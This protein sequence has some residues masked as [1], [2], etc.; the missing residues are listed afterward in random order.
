[1]LDI[2]DLDDSV[3][4]T[5]FTLDDFR[6][7]LLK[8]LEANRSVLDAAP[9]GLYTVVPPSETIKAVGPGVVWC[10]RQKTRRGG[11]AGKPTE[12]VN[13]LQPYFLVYVLDDGNIRLSFAQPKQILG[14]YRDLC[15]GKA[16]PYEELC[17][18]FDQQTSDGQ[19]MAHYDK[20][21]QKAIASIAATFRKR[22]AG[23]LQSGRGFVIPD[24][25][26]QATENSD[27]EL[28]TWLVIKSP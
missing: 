1:V 25:S 6:I 22:V 26:E 19:S 21:L 23:G 10:F 28:V 14:I 18:L 7:D 2:D 4:L 24:Q 15:G 12:Q 16:V 20:L 5:E 17:N 13:P 3:S 9:F 8:Y 11:D 27:F